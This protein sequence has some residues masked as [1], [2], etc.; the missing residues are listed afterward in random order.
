MKRSANPGGECAE[1]SQV[2]HVSRLIMDGLKDAGL[3]TKLQDIKE[4]GFNE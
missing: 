4:R 2:Q 1:E 3:G